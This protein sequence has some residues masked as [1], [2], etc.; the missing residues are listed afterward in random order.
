MPPSVTCMTSQDVTGQ[1]PLG[2]GFGVP[3]SAAKAFTV[4]PG[5]WFLAPAFW[6]SHDPR[7]LRAPG[8]E[9][10]VEANPACPQ[11]LEVLNAPVEIAV[12]EHFMEMDVLV[13]A[14]GGQEVSIA[15]G[16]RIC[17]IC[18]MDEERR[19]ARSQFCESYVQRQGEPGTVGACLAD[20][21]PVSDGQ[22]ASLTGRLAGV[23]LGDPG[24][25]W[26]A[27][28]TVAASR[29]KLA[30]KVD[31]QARLF[32]ALQAEIEERRK[33]MNEPPRD[34]KSKAYRDDICAKVHSLHLCPSEFQE[35]FF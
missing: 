29:Y 3:S 9:A 6:N 20:D 24:R 12:M 16:D 13:R 21:G 10:W 5:G 19:W 32:P 8:D 35:A 30:E 18:P 4:Y 26:D 23:R 28:P 15:P 22:E 27:Q 14:T 33:R 17:Q 1:G 34:Q 11:G 31:E 25:T 2:P 7:E